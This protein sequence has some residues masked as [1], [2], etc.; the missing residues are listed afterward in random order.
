MTLDNASLGAVKGPQANI[1]RNASVGLDGTFAY[2]PACT[3]CDPPCWRAGWELTLQ[4]L[5]FAEVLRALE[6][7]RQVLQ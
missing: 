2:H 1:L 7:L 6:A 3:C 5:T 4:N